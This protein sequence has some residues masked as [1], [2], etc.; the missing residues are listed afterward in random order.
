MTP[1]D[2]TSYTLLSRAID[3]NDQSAWNELHSRYE[4]FIYYILREI[5]VPDN[6]LDDLCQQVMVNLM[7]SLKSY[8]RSKAKFRTW[9]KRIIKNI[10]YMHY[11]KVYAHNN[12]IDALTAEQ[13][14]NQHVIESEFEKLIDE[15]WENYITTLAMDKIQSTYKGNGI[16]VFQR[17]LAGESVAQISEDLSIAETTVYTLRQRVKKS[18]LQEI[19]HLIQELEG[20]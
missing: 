2:G 3:L 17:T 7:K 13:S 5:N 15:E 14:S 12:K 10:A 8:D 6:D 9:M 16:E 1:D 11:R 19:R 18:L 4:K 20:E